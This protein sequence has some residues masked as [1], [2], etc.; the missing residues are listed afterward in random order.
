MRITVADT[1]IGIKPED[2]G[3]LFEP[4]RQLDSSLTRKYEG[5]GLGLAICRRL[6]Q[7][8]GGEITAH[9]DYGKGSRFIVTLP[10]ESQKKP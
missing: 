8:L 2:M 4:L 6:A 1:G 10:L 5:T 9:S 3:K 7:M